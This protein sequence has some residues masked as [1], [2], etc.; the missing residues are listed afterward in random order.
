MKETIKTDLSMSDYKFYFYKKN[1]IKG[2]S[3]V[4]KLFLDSWLS[5]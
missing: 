1:N 3:N 5:Y 2:I 4:I